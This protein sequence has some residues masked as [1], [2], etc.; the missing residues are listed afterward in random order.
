MDLS[1]GDEAVVES[2]ERFVDVGSSFPTDAQA[3]EAAQP[4]EVPPENP[5]VGAQPGAVSCSVAGDHG[6]D[7][8]LADLVAVDIMVVAEV[9]EYRVRLTRSCGRYSH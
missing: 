5:A 3:A 8:S 7:A 1:L 9:G 6:H 2:E 4:G